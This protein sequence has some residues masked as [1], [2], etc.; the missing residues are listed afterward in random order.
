M[1]LYI[2][3]QNP[4]IAVNRLQLA[5]S[6]ASIVR[7]LTCQIY[8]LHRSTVSLLSR[9]VFNFVLGTLACFKCCSHLSLT[10]E[11]EKRVPATI[12]L[13][14]A[15]YCLPFS[16]LLFIRCSDRSFWPCLAVYIPNEY[17]ISVYSRPNTFS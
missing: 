9:A 1:E 2:S 16:L 12:L 5:E 10:C 4:N 17:A 8:S 3:P 11:R 7:F 15:Y 13:T 6:S 14:T